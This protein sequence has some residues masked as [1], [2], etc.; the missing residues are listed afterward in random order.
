[1]EVTDKTRADVKVCH[2]KS[3]YLLS[4]HSY[5]TDI[6]LYCCNHGRCIKS[7]QDFFFVKALLPQLVILNIELTI[8]QTK[9][10][11]FS[12]KV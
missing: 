10:S 3:K 9:V 12:Y 5:R 4:Y 11:F 6:T 8:D 1:M 7:A 2:H